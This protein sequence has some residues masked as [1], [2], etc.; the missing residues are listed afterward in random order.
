MRAARWSYGKRPSAKA[1]GLSSR[2]T[3]IGPVDPGNGTYR[4]AVRKDLVTV[5]VSGDVMTGRGI[6]QILPGAGDPA[7]W[8][9]HLRDARAY[10]ELA[11]QTNGPIPHPVDVTWPWGDALALLDEVDPAVRLINLETSI[12]RSNDVAAKAVCYRMSPDNVGC[13]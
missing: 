12:T 5:C 10:V 9:R 1:S 13:L 2:G 6:D 11:E 8:E 7:L 3:A 4:D